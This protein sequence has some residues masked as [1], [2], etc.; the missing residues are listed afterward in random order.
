MFSLYKSKF[1]SYE[2]FFHSDSK[3]VEQFFCSDSAYMR[4]ETLLSELLSAILY[5]SQSA[6]RGT[7]DM[8]FFCH[9][10]DN[11]QQIIMASCSSVHKKKNYDSVSLKTFRK[12]SFSDDFA[13]KTDF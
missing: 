12:W 7:G 4:T 5:H 8:C 9:L 10:F 2:F 3:L 13:V 6:L 1:T 11:Q